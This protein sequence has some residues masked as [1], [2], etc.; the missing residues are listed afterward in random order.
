MMASHSEDRPI[1][2]FTA[3]PTLLVSIS[4]EFFNKSTMFLLYSAY[5]HSAV[6]NPVIKKLHVKSGAFYK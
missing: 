4:D 5:P 3:P 1:T 6:Y 2:V